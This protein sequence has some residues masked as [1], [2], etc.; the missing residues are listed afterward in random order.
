MERLDELLKSFYDVFCWPE[1][2]GGSVVLGFILA[3]KPRRKTS[4]DGFAKTPKIL[5]DIDEKGIVNCM[6][7][8]FVIF[9]RSRVKFWLE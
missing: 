5:R 4:V 1:D 3:R 8:H 9:D 2:P 6:I 7:R